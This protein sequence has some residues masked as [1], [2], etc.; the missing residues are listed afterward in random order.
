ML[1]YETM[2]VTTRS[3]SN[4]APKNTHADALE[5]A[6]PTAAI[7]LQMKTNMSL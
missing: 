7:C 1:R 3:Q 6:P 2:S 5:I 4:F